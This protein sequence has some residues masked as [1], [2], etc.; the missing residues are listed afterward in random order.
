MVLGFRWRRDG[1]LV[2]SVIVAVLIVGTAAVVGSPHPAGPVAV[3]GGSSP[4]GPPTLPTLPDD[5]FGRG[6]LVYAA[7]ARC[8]PL[9]QVAD[10]REFAVPTDA[11]DVSA[12]TLSPD[13]RWLGYPVGTGFALRDLS[14]S[15]EFRIGS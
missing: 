9:V 1:W 3:P 14:R 13:G 4:A 2:G 11:P 6:V 5:P 15:D 12:V 7:C 8:R 10:G